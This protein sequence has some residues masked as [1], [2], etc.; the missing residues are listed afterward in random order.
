[1]CQS[2]V[3]CHIN[4][5]VKLEMWAKAQTLTKQIQSAVVGK[6]KSSFPSS[7]P[8]SL[9]PCLPPPSSSPSSIPVSLLPSHL[10]PSSSSPSS[11]PVPLL[12]SHLPPSSSSPSCSFPSW[13]QI[14]TPPRWANC[15]F[16]G[17]THHEI[18]LS[19]QPVSVVFRDVCPSIWALWVAE[20]PW[21][22]EFLPW[23]ISKLSLTSWLNWIKNWTWILFLFL[24]S[25][26]KLC[27]FGTHWP[28]LGA[29]LKEEWW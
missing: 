3:P 14:K 10:L 28:S 6:E 27:A 1:M 20:L 2:C 22:C 25:R 13:D 11:L 23:C 16:L 5:T 7:L 4:A 17:K 19:I 26:W 9:H 29:D 21:S 12:P 8:V 24:T 18:L 15:Y